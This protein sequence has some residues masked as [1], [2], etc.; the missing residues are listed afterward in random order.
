MAQLTLNNGTSFEGDENHLH[1]VLTSYLRSKAKRSDEAAD[2]RPV[3]E[4]KSVHRS[5][6]RMPQRGWTTE[7]DEQM[8][9]LWKQGIKGKEIA[10]ILN[11]LD[12]R[13]DA[14]HVHA[15]VKTLREEGVNIPYRM[16]LP[17]GK[18]RE[19]SVKVPVVVTPFPN[20]DNGD[21]A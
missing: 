10:R 12:K 8:L 3:Q 13:G 4:V 19:E 11:R 9:N 17:H 21:Q 20:G 1:T 18:K 15:R 6:R 2:T 7:E 5:T 14:T 16:K